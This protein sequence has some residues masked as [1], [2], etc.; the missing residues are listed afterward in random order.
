MSEADLRATLA[1][2][3]WMQS[4]HFEGRGTHWDTPG[5]MLDSDKEPYFGLADAALAVLAARSP[6]NLMVDR[7]MAVIDV[8][9]PDSVTRATGR[10]ALSAALGERT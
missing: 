7:L 8:A 4:A 2:A 5:A 6:S 10:L 3:M 1:R 9:N